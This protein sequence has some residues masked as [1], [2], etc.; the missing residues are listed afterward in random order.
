MAS[1]ASPIEAAIAVNLLLAG[2]A[3]LRDRI[4]SRNK[5]FAKEVEQLETEVGQQERIAM[6]QLRNTLEFWGK[7][8]R[9]LWR[10]GLASG[11]LAAASLYVALWH[12][13]SAPVGAWLLGFL[14][15]GA[16][17]NPVAMVCMWAAEWR[18]HAIASRQKD[19]LDE[20]AA[21]LHEDSRA[22]R[23]TVH[24]QLLGRK[25]MF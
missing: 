20:A 13:Q 25:R 8:G 6:A 7:W 5:S 4:S 16:Y 10:V 3:A 9:R 21:K 1:Y 14:W 11:L 19:I 23:Q 15:I 2:W 12:F 24:D 18:G 22:V 17:L